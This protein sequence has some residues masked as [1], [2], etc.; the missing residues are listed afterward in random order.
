MKD[1]SNLKTIFI[2]GTDT[3]VGKSVFTAFLALDLQAKGKNIAICKPLQTGDPKDT[4]NLKELT[5]NKIPIYNTYSLKL[6][7]APSVA[8]RDENTSIDI[9]KI[10]SEIKVLENKY[11][12]VII[13]GIGGITVPLL[14]N[15]KYLVT[16]LINDLNYPTIVVARPNLGTINHTTLTLEFAKK[17]NIDLLGFVIS[18]YDENT[19]D[20]VIKTAPEEIEKI[21][22]VKC[23]MKLSK[24]KEV[25]FD[26]INSL[27]N[28]YASLATSS[29]SSSKAP[30][31]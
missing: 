12:V 16:D 17:E 11:D 26:S 28:N 9:K 25:N 13:E 15:R 31:S 2:T 8:A 3:E 23:L 20:T 21:T 27:V 10:I 14:P 5:G 24:L 29:S 7:A 30:N 1:L 4:D 6:P 18:G 19:T 22:K